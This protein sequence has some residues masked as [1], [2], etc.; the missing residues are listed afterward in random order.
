MRFASQADTQ[1]AYSSQIPYGP[2]NP[3][4]IAALPAE[5]AKE[6]PTFKDNMVGALETDNEF[7]VD[8]GEELEQRFNAWAAKA[9][10]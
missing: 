5:K 8:N 7:W 3:D 1:A 2:V 10:Q 6:M 9:T 4:A